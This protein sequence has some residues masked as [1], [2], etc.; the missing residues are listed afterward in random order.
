MLFVAKYNGDNNNKGPSNA[1][2][3]CRSST[4]TPITGRYVNGSFHLK[5]GSSRATAHLLRPAADAGR[6][7]ET[8]AQVGVAERLAKSE[9]V[10]GRM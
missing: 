4:S 2:R 7:R 9:E 5:R 1:G 6:A 8:P 10:D 3:C